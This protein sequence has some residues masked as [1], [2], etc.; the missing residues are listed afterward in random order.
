MLNENSACKICRLGS[1]RIGMNAHGED[2]RVPTLDWIGKEKVINHH[3]NVPYRV[4]SYD[5]S[6][7]HTEDNG[8]KNKIIHGDNL[9][10]LYRN[11][12][13]V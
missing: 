3:M 7:Q 6:G 13:L 12:E 11:E 5:S 8:S 9:E 10:V 1:I 4:Y 2:E